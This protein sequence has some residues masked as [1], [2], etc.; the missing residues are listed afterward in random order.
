MGREGRQ[1]KVERREIEIKSGGERERGILRIGME[2]EMEE[3]GREKGSL[4]S[5]CN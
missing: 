5:D 4:R 2:R 3:R 1:Q